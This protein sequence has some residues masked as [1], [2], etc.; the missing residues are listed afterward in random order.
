[1]TEADSE[2]LKAILATRS[3]EALNQ[4]V[5]RHIDR[6]RRVIRGMVASDST[7]DD[8][9][10]ETF[11]R[12]TRGIS[13]FLGDSSVTTWLT[14]IAIHVALDHCDKQKRERLS[15]HNE[16]LASAP[17]RLN[18]DPVERAVSAETEST[19]QRALLA[20]PAS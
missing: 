4:L 16:L 18:A 1:M 8:L 9:V 19:I 6:V 7:V 12:A 10:Q 14:R 11:L 15:F 17:A 20:L 3:R 5:A 2:L 13:S